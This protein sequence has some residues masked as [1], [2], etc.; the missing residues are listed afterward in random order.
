MS[1]NRFSRPSHL[2]A[3]FLESLMCVFCIRLSE[4]KMFAMSYNLRTFVLS[5][6]DSGDPPRSFLAA[7]SNEMHTSSSCSS[8]SFFSSLPQSTPPHRNIRTNLCE[9]RPRDFSLLPSDPPALFGLPLSDVVV[10]EV[11][12]EPP[13]KWPF[14]ILK[15]KAKLDTNESMKYVCLCSFYF[16]TYLSSAVGIL[17]KP[18]QVYKF[19]ALRTTT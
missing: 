15:E 2:K 17:L 19:F 4:L 7:A 6:D 13:L 3:G 10:V 8:C 12:G 18:C 9:R 16:W 5:W 14:L 1:F 11:P